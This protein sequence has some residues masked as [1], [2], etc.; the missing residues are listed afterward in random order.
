MKAIV[1]GAGG[2]IGN[3][4]VSKLKD[5]GYYVIGIDLKYP[6]YQNSNAN[7]FILNAVWK[8]S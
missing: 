5:E 7:L 1:M 4:L 6:D 8:R 2:F 3:H